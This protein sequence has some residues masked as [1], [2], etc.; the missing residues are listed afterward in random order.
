V[1]RQRPGSGH[2]TQAGAGDGA[3]TGS[4]EAEGDNSADT[5]GLFPA[6]VNG[7]GVCYKIGFVGLV[8]FS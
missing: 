3:L 2:G 4:G 8:S 1:E 6:V 7:N 5:K